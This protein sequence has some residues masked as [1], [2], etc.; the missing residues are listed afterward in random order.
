MTY[1]YTD[2]SFAHIPTDYHADKSNLLIQD[3]KLFEQNSNTWGSQRP[4]N[5]STLGRMGTD[6]SRVPLP[7]IPNDNACNTLSYEKPL[8]NRNGNV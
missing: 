1:E 2:P 7:P 6:H 3:D 4:G 8:Y 5:T